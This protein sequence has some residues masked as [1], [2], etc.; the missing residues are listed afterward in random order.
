MLGIKGDVRGV[1]KGYKFGP[2]LGNRKN[3]KLN[4]LSRVLNIL[5]DTN[6]F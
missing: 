4:V 6:Y 3:L 5:K 1:K 2:N